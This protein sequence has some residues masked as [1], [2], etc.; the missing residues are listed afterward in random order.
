MCNG[1][2]QGYCNYYG[3][4]VSELNN[5]CDRGKC[6]N[7][8]DNFTDEE[9][10]ALSRSTIEA[11]QTIHDVQKCYSKETKEAHTA[12]MNELLAVRKDR[13]I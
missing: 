4:K 5:N 13:M 9:I 6:M 1:Y 8:F 12:L 10:Y 2:S 3:V 7:R 11:A